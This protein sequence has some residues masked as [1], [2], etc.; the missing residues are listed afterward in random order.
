MKDFNKRIFLSLTGWKMKEL[1]VKLEELKKYKIDTACVF[2]SAVPANEHKALLK[3]LDKSHLKY[4]PLVHLKNEIKKE[5][6]IF[7]QKRFKTKHFNCHLDFFKNKLEID[8]KN[9][10]YELH[11]GDNFK[12]I[13]MDEI[14][15]FCVDIAHFMISK[16][17][18]TIDYR[19]LMK[20]KNKK[21]YFKCNH[22]SGFTF[23]EKTDLHYVTKLENFEYIRKVPKFL[24]GDIIALEVFESIKG[25]LAI[26]NYIVEMLN[27]KNV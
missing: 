11:P 5:D 18:D 1:L 17:K 7:F 8:K 22:I 24:L 15:G 16:V 6:V 20:L 14:G 3:A 13:K 27:K 25:Q 12:N 2:L 19:M 23:D 4:V 10:Y 26:K 21:K 9:L